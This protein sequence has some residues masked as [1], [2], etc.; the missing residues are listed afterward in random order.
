MLHRLLK[1]FDRTFEIVLAARVDGRQGQSDW[2][3]R[4]SRQE[5]VDGGVGLFELAERQL[6]IRL[7]GEE[8]VPRSLFSDQLMDVIE[9]RRALFTLNGPNDFV[10]FCL[11]VLRA[12][13]LD[14]I[15][16]TTGTRLIGI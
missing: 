6:N 14:L 5:F 15:A 1:I 12:A 13:K 10:E 8:R 7:N 3:I 11:N 4:R 9:C 16:A 2:I